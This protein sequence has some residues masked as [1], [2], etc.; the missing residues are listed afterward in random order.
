VSKRVLLKIGG[1]AFEH[2]E[3]FFSLAFSIK[4]LGQVDFILVHGGG[5]EISGALKDAGLESEFIDGLRITTAAQIEIVE[6][7]LSGS[8]DISRRAA[9]LAAGCPERRKI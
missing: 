4:Q 7:V 1:K 6:K 2:K 9:C 5:A 3:A 8:P